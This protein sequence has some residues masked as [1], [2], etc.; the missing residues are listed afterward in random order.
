[1]KTEP[2]ILLGALQA[3]IVLGVSFGLKLTLEQQ[4]ALLAVAAIVISIATRHLVTPNGKSKRKKAPTSTALLVL[5]LAFVPACGGALGTAAK[6]AHVVGNALEI[7]DGA[8]SGAEAYFARHP[9]LDNEAAVVDAVA[10]VRAAIDSDEKT[11]AVETYGEL[12]SLLDGLGV[13]SA[14]PPDGG[15]ETDAPEPEPFEL[16]T[17]EEFE[18]AL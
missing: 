5:L 18:A 16:P 13:L 2:A 1:M 8:A 11:K 15:A 10:L 6:V 9:S 4:A 12:R 7:L 17:D 14:T 3:L